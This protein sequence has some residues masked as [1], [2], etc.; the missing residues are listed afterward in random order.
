MTRRSFLSKE[1]CGHLAG[2]VSRL[3]AMNTRCG[4]WATPIAATCERP[5]AGRGVQ[6]GLH[7]LDVAV[8]SLQRH[9]RDVIGLG[10]RGHPAA[11]GVPDL[12][13]ARRGRH[14]VPA[15]I[16]ELDHLPA[17]L[18][19]AQVAVKVETVQ[20]LKV[21]ASMPV[22]HVVHRDR[23][24]PLEPRRHGNLR[25]VA[26][27]RRMRSPAR[28]RPRNRKPRRYQA[29]PAWVA[30]NLTLVHPWQRG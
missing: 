21:Q 26:Y 15:V 18:Q 6:V 19:L 14:R 25:D 29:E 8:G 30:P 1:N 23:Y 5:A 2:S 24:R 17:D 22:E 4:S 3:R 9:H 16:Q 27:A 20:A 7:H 12:L 28:Q 10:E 13:Q 11:E